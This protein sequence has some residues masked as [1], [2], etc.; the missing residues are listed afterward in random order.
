MCCWYLQPETPVRR[1]AQPPAWPPASLAQRPPLL[2]GPTLSFSR[3]SSSSRCRS[4]SGRKSVR[5]EGSLPSLAYRSRAAPPPPPLPPFAASC[6]AAAPS[7]LLGGCRQA[8]RAKRARCGLRTCC[9]ST[10]SAP[11]QGSA[12]RECLGRLQHAHLRSL[13]LRRLRRGRLLLLLLL[14]PKAVVKRQLVLLLRLGLLGPLPLLLLQGRPP[15]AGHRVSTQPRLPATKDPSPHTDRGLGCTP[16]TA[17]PLLL[18]QTELSQARHGRFVPPPHPTRSASSSASCRS[19]FCSALSRSSMVSR[20]STNCSR[21]TRPMVSFLKACS[22][23]WAEGGRSGAQG[24]ICGACGC[25]SRKPV[26]LASLWLRMLLPSTRHTSEEAAPNWRSPAPLAAALLA[27]SNCRCCSSRSLSCRSMRRWSSVDPEEGRPRAWQAARVG[28]GSRRDGSGGGDWLQ[29]CCVSGWRCWLTYIAAHAI[30]AHGEERGRPAERK[31]SERWT[32][33]PM[34]QRSIVGAYLS[35][36]MQ[37]RR[38][39]NAT[40]S[41]R[42]APAA[43][44]TRGIELRTAQTAE[45]DTQLSTAVFAGSA[46]ASWRTCL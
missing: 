43:T 40:R 3:S 25:G 10:A 1:A 34:G 6:A 39:E 21:V 9:T 13:L 2:A 35:L 37:G 36:R 16:W 18:P 7:L 29:G 4:L 30:I 42:A 8:C 22:M 28:R 44:P 19:R 32:R 46:R 20:F 14:L 5:T 26:A 31:L 15:T 27:S 45:Q 11:A 41:C 12:S 23:A 17:A 38:Q 24:R 33:A